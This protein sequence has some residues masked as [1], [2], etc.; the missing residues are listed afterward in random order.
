MLRNVVALYRRCTASL[1]ARILRHGKAGGPGIKPVKISGRQLDHEFSVQEVSTPGGLSV[2]TPAPKS[3]F[4]HG[5]SPAIF[6]HPYDAIVPCSGHYQGVRGS[7]HR[8]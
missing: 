4:G 7:E 5:P 6:G 2:S 3:I 1:G 8:L